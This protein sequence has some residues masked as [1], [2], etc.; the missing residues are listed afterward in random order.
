MTKTP[1]K[2]AYKKRRQNTWP[3]DLVYDKII[4]GSLGNLNYVAEFEEIWFY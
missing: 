4:A 3:V 1:S 2:S